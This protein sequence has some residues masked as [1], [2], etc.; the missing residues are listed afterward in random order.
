MAT[1]STKATIRF[2]VIVTAFAIASCAKEKEAEPV[3]YYGDSFYPLEKGLF[4]ETR[5]DTSYTNVLANPSHSQGTYYQR[6]VIGDTLSGTPGEVKYRTTIYRRS[7]TTQPWQIKE[8]GIVARRGF[9]VLR[10][11]PDG[12]IVKLVLPFRN[13]QR[14]NGYE[15]RPEA[16][17]ASPFQVTYLGQATLYNSGFDSVAQ[18]VE[19]S[20]TSCLSSR[21]THSYYSAGKGPVAEYRRETIFQQDPE[22]PCPETLL[23]QRETIFRSLLVRFGKI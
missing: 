3:V 4:Y 2:L 14:W 9:Q 20:D 21:F 16:E 7:D 23:I 18:V 17:T 1:P 22:N 12:A 6:E 8:F 15:F 11:Y 19:I 5:I 10:E 13:R